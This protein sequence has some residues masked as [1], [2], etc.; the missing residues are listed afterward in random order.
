MATG[1]AV[2]HKAIEQLKATLTVADDHLFSDTKL[3][4]VWQWARKLEKDQAA[5][6]ELKHMRRIEPY[7]RSLEAYAGVLEVFVQGY[8]PMAFVWVNFTLTLKELSDELIYVTGPDQ[9][10]ATSKV[11]PTHKEPKLTKGLSWRAT[12]QACWKI[13][14]KLSVTLPASYLEWTSLRRLFKTAQT[15]VTQLLWST[16]M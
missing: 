7:L 13:S 1:Q 8:S 4:H 3:E 12:I 2:V 15:S 9:A 6:R 11:A 14:F 16:V 5:R 10:D